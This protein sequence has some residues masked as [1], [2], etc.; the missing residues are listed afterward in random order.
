MFSTDGEG[1]SAARSSLTNLLPNTQTQT[2]SH[3]APP[4]ARTA[5][6]VSIITVL[7]A[8]AGS[9]REAALA[10]RF[11]ISV[12]MD[13]YFAAI[14]IPNIL[15]LV[16]IAGTLSPVFI[17]ILLQESPQDDPHKAS[18]TF[19]VIT[20]F[21]LLIFVAIVALGTLTARLWLP[22]LFPGFSPSTMA[23]AVRLVSIIFP[24]LPFLAAAGILTA[25]LN[26]FHKFWL[27][28]FAP[29]VSSLCVIVA[30]LSFY[31]ERAIHA[32]AIAT[33]LGFVLQCIVLLPGAA[34]LSIRYHPILDFHH[35]AIRK[36][37]RLGIPLF[38][39][40]VVANFSGVME[41]N[42]ASRIS[43]GA[44]SALTYAVRLFTMPANFLAAPLAV[45]AYPTFAREAVRERRGELANQVS[46]LFRLIVFIFL[47][48]T[49]WM[50]LNAPAVTRILYEHG[51]FSFSD[52]EITSHI[53]SIYSLG[54]LP[55]AIA[56]VLLRCFFAIEDTMSPLLTE[57]MN[58]VVFVIGASFLSVRFGITG[59]VA[60]RSGTFFLV[61]GILMFILVRR[62]LL[63][64][65]GA[66]FFLLR[67]CAAAAALGVVNWSIW[68][69]AQPLFDSGNTLLKLA[70]TLAGLVISGGVYLGVALLL[71]LGEAR[72][73]MRTVWDLVPG[74]GAGAVK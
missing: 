44:V 43:A 1:K 74:A 30:A 9:L 66:G 7:V 54:I 24:A 60:V 68:R 51:R 71:R 38:L 16:L 33:A 55:N 53:L 6:V 62:D 48:A 17:P 11:G 59:L 21:A 14:F 72:Q 22:W 19:S 2:S 52:S 23:E 18:V 29:A 5:G 63:R 4:R 39:Y 69:M 8:I 73:I 50:V 15:Y 49:V 25:L 12:T 26:G 10:S 57:I 64:L 37:L 13:A 36:L 46:R 61:V 65:N 31:G 70:I 58:L 32:V 67:A 28:A 34:S 45:V 3:V 56:I 27:P 20:N 40:L 35:P 42:F 47:P 41:R